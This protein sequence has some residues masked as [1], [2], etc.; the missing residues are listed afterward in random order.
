ML[1]DGHGAIDAAHIAHQANWSRETFGPGPRT[2]GVLD[3]ICKEVDEVL[4]D[5]YDL[6]EWVDLIILSFDGAWRALETKA[7][8]TGESW[9]P[10]QIID[11]VK[12]KQAKNEARVWPDWRTM[13]ADKAIEHDRS[14]E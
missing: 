13:S 7:E 5:P 14:A 6:N 3:H 10:Q 11:A 9:S 12:A 2:E 1:Y 8:M 4:A